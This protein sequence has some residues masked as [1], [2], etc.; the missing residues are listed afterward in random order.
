ML[1]RRR[2]LCLQWLCMVTVAPS[3][4]VHGHSF[5]HGK[6]TDMLLACMSIA[7]G[8]LAVLYFLVTLLSTLLGLIG[9][10]YLLFVA[11]WLATGHH[12]WLM[13][14]LMSESVGISGALGD[15]QC[16]CCMLVEQWRGCKVAASKLGV[17]SNAY[18]RHTAWS[19]FTQ[20]QSVITSRTPLLSVSIAQPD[21]DQ[22]VLDTP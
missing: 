21:L 18:A 6:P 2:Q 16:C 4:A 1:V 17:C 9:M 3:M 10:R 8:R 13:P 12:F 7:P 19:P 20:T 22:P 15:L 14:N 11:V 5:A